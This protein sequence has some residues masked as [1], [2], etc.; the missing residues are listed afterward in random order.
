EPQ[1]RA[2]A[3]GSD[4]EARAS[5]QPWPA[6]LDAFLDG[7]LALSRLDRRLDDSPTGDVL[8]LRVARAVA[9]R[10]E[11][12]DEPRTVRT[13]AER[14]LAL[15]RPGASRTL[16][17][18]LLLGLGED[19]PPPVAAEAAAATPVAV[20][21]EDL[22]ALASYAIDDPWTR[23]RDDALAVVETDGGLE[24]LVHVADAATSVLCGGPVDGAAMRR[25]TAHFWPDGVI[26]ML[27]AALAEARLSLDAD[28]SPRRAFTIRFRCT[29]GSHGPTLELVRLGFSLVR[30]AA[31]RTYEEVD[32]A[33][34]E[35][36]GVDDRLLA[37]L[38]EHLLAVRRR[39]VP[40]DEPPRTE[41]RL[42]V[43]G[44]GERIDLKTLAV[45]TP[46]RRLI[47]ELALA[48]GMAAAGW[49][50]E[51]EVPLI[52]RVQDAP[53]PGRRPSRA[54]YTLTPDEHHAMGG[55]LYAHVTS[56]LRRYVDLLNQ[57][58]LAARLTG[59]A[60]R[61]DPQ[62]DLQRITL[63]IREVLDRARDL[64]RDAHRYWALRWLALR[65]EEVFDAELRLEPQTLDGSRPPRVMVL[66]VSVLL[67][68]DGAGPLVEAAR[69]ATSAAARTPGFVPVRVRVEVTSAES[70][71][72]RAAIAP[73]G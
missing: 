44:D 27:P 40:L 54:T 34:R 5:H 64:G 12:S 29:A 33:L 66:P 35:P 6:D 59:G 63:G 4:G 39:R 7:L 3:R 62:V 50:R 28:G 32:V 9:A 1:P 72:A 69:A 53:A 17:A 73:S 42:V 70:L 22:T 43:E 14:L 8:S 23:L 46:A 20:E 24:V 60:V 21:V 58:Q 2:E 52:Y 47:E 19:F 10:I 15:R 41:A 18:R 38:W 16:R 57:R 30:I 51:H 31:N 45:G 61:A 37:R 25:G 65:K 11:G 55:A 68:V 48:A 36:A 26:P 71:S 67:P 13:L 49:A 56:P